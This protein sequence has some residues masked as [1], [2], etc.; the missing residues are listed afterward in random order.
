MVPNVSELHINW[1]GVGFRTKDWGGV[2]A[3][4]A[5]KKLKIGKMKGRSNYGS[6]IAFRKIIE[7]PQFV[8]MFLPQLS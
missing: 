4:S 2:W 6:L 5:V 3:V 1:A 8:Q 7:K